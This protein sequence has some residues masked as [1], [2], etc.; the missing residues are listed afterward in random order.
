MNKQIISFKL[1]EL[2][3]ESSTVCVQMCVFI[4]FTCK[5]EKKKSDAFHLYSSQILYWEGG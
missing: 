1:N 3:F 4:C 2:I 5:A